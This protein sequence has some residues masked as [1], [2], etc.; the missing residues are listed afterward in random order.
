M[1]AQVTRACT[2]SLSVVG[3]GNQSAASW[4]ILALA[5]DSR[6]GSLRV[7]QQAQMSPDR[8]LQATPQNG[9]WQYRTALLTRNMPSVE[10]A[11]TPEQFPV[12]HSSRML[13]DPEQQ[14]AAQTLQN[15]AACV[16]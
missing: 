15:G 7:G 5:E 16:T 2:D 1:P 4:S 14:V 10:G 12:D 8:D 3:N 13:V 6:T 9:T 11:V